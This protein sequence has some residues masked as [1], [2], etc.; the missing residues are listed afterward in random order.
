MGEEE[1]AVARAGRREQAEGLRGG[2]EG[3]RAVERG[4]A[5]AL[6]SGATDLMPI[7]LPTIAMRINRPPKKNTKK[8]PTPR[9]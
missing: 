8:E 2:T 4:S 9:P 1:G 7:L 3:G 5:Q 6:G